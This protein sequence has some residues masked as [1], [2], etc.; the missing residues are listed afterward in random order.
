MPRPSQARL[1]SRTCSQ[2][3][4]TAMIHETDYATPCTASTEVVGQPTGIWT[5]RGTTTPSRTQQLEASAGLRDAE[6]CPK[7]VDEDAASEGRLGTEAAAGSDGLEVIGDYKVHPMA[8]D[9]ANEFDEERSAAHAD[10]VESI[11]IAGRVHIPIEFHDGLL[12]CGRNRLRAVLELRARGY[13]IELPTVAWQPRGDESV[14][15]H[16]WSDNMNRRHYSDDQRAALATKWLPRIRAAQ[17]ARRRASQFGSSERTAVARRPGPPEKAAAVPRT[18]QERFE[19]S[20][21]GQIAFLASVSRH[22]AEQAVALAD[23]VTAGT[24]TV[25]DFDAVVGGALRLRDVVPARPRS[26]RRAVP[27]AKQL[28]D[29]SGDA[30]SDDA[31]IVI[32]ADFETPEDRPVTEEIVREHW[33]RFKQLFAIADHQELRRLTV[34]II[35]EEQKAFGARP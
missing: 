1:V 35:A 11:R 25:E 26:K 33:E 21:A 27:T 12:I 29:S 4:D 19:S 17:E 20:T 31:P 32:D 6:A 5:M 2:R 14:E 15:Q 34:K 8:T 16:I 30:T 3:H 13:S 28:T 10:F 9:M 7:R 23:G 22:K 18:R 24:R